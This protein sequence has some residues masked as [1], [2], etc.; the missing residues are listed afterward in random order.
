MP[1][2]ANNTILSP[3]PAES[4]DA[5]AL[6]VMSVLKAG[7]MYHMTMKPGEFAEID[8]GTQWTTI[9]FKSAMPPR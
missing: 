4:W 8:A 1:L 2:Y 7:E 5:D 9:V 3:S 6:S